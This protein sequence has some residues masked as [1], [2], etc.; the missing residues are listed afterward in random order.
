MQV[1]EIE[2]EPLYGKNL[3][4]SL[5]VM[6]TRNKL[7]PVAENRTSSFNIQPIHPILFLDEIAQ[8]KKEKE[9]RYVEE[10]FDDANLFPGYVFRDDAG[11]DINVT[12]P[13]KLLANMTT[14][15]LEEF[16]A[17]VITKYGKDGRSRGNEAGGKESRAEAKKYEQLHLKVRVCSGV[18]YYLGQRVYTA[19]HGTK[20]CKSKGSAHLLMSLRIAT[21]LVLQRCL[22]LHTK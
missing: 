6:S 2:R 8:L 21:K 1:E 14:E 5:S 22:V 3:S 16:R 19:E 9:S 10:S 11:E 20:T 17:K 4:L 15:K 13:S 12:E 7:G 18:S